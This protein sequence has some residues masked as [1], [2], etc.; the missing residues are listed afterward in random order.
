MVDAKILN[1]I[2]TEWPVYLELDDNKFSVE[3]DGETYHCVIG[4]KKHYQK[5]WY[6]FT[7]RHT[8]FKC[9]WVGIEDFTNAGPEGPLNLPPR[10]IVFEEDLHDPQSINN[11][12]KKFVDFYMGISR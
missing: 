5:P 7:I 1:Q 9:E 3:M 2:L 12:K 11:A 6:Q 10:K 4:T 8:N